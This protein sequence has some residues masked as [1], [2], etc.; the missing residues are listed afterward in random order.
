M[1]A[2]LPKLDWPRRPDRAAEILTPMQP[3]SPSFVRRQLF[4]RLVMN[5]AALLGLVQAAIAHWVWG[6]LLARPTGGAAL[7]IGAALA[8]AAANA[9]IVPALQRTRRGRGRAGRI[10][11]FYMETG[12]ATLIVGLSVLASWAAFA[13]CGSAAFA[14]G[15]APAAILTGFRAAS[16]LFVVAIAAQAA[17]GFTFGQRHVE[18]TTTRVPLPKLHSDLTGLRIVQISDLHI[19]N[20]LEEAR[21]DAMIARTNATRPDVVVLTG[22]IFDFDPAH[23]DDGARRLAGLRARYGVYAILGNHDHYVG[24]DRVAVALARHAPGIRMLRDEL[25]RLPVAEPLYLAGVED[26]GGRWFERGLQVAAIDALADQRPA[27]GP[28]VL[29]VHQPEMF[30]HA[31]RRGFPLVLA[32]HT[33]GGQIALPVGRRNINLARVMTPL[34]RGAYRHAD[35][36]LYVNRGLGV[37]GPAVRIH[38]SR[39]IAVLELEPA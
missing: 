20:R 14:L 36:V 15:A 30:H 3:S 34:T 10:A 23:V 21:L 26:P 31:A 18:V 37:G 24:A 1:R 6:V 8:L 25:V 2:T 5:L 29:L 28:V 7:W 17:W 4:S 13:L 39:E 11:R 9:A 32:G 12:V 19:G 35:S 38:C 33:H 27:D 22:D 16:A